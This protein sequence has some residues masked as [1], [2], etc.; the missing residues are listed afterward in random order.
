MLK[1]VTSA[2]SAIAAYDSVAKGAPGSIG[3]SIGKGLGTGG[4]A[5]DGGAFADLVKSA[6]QEA[7]RIGKTAEQASIAA[8]NDRADIGKVVT[9][10][11][12]AELTLQTVVTVRDRV[13]EAYREIMRM[14]I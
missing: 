2:A 1:P 10:V 8:V 5:G 9:A 4:G 6:I 12:E 3:G 14:P 11:A 7:A 13:I